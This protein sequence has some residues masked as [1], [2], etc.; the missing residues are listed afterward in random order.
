[1][2]PYRTLKPLALRAQL[3][4]TRTNAWF[5]PRK[6]GLQAHWDPPRMRG[7][8]ATSAASSPPSNA[9]C[10]ATISR[11]FLWR[12]RTPQ[13]AR[14]VQAEPT[15]P[16]SQ[17]PIGFAGDEAESLRRGGLQSLA[18]DR[19]GFERRQSHLPS[20]PQAMRSKTGRSIKGEMPSRQT[21]SNRLSIE[22]HRRARRA[23]DPRS[24]SS[25]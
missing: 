12:V 16:R 25:G 19:L 17:F 8:L 7:M 1:M 5:R 11:L 2:P 15:A 13:T 4:T 18:T 10:Q 14:C 24:S 23:G 6:R 9:A 22:F 3:S 21:R 20:G